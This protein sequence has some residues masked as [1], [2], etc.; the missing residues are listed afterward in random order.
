M[1]RVPLCHPGV[2]ALGAGA[3]PA[4]GL[5]LLIPPLFAALPTLPE[6][7]SFPG[8]GIQVP[9]GSPGT[10]VTLGTLQLPP[11]PGE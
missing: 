4:P 5:C 8:E 3:V 1:P 2:A 9:H 10:M 6:G 7:P 11:S